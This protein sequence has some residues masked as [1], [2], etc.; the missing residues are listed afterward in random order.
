MQKRRKVTKTYIGLYGNVLP[1]DSNSR[2]LPSTKADVTAAIYT[3]FPIRAYVFGRRGSI[4]NGRCARLIF[5]NFGKIS[6]I[7]LKP[8]NLAVYRT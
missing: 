8:F 7:Y 5:K 2:Y 6:K 4:Q 1:S 3:D